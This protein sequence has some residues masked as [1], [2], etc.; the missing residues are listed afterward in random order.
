MTYLI[1]CAMAGV[2]LFLL[3]KLYLMKKSAREISEGFRRKLN[4][5]T[6]TQ[7]RISGHDKDMKRLASDV[8]EQ[9]VRLR[10]EQLIYEQGNTALKNA[11]TNISHDIRTP[12]TAIYGYLDMIQKTDDPGK[13][14]RYIAIMKDRAELM[15][16]LTEELFRYSVILADEN[17]LEISEVFVNQVL[18]E[19]ISG[20]YPALSEKGIIPQISITE[21]RI[22]R[23][24]DKAALSRVFAN[25][26]NNAVKYSDGDLEIVLSDTG[27]VRFTNTAKELSTVDVEQLFDR[28]YTVEAAHHST[29]LGLSIART[30]VE[31][32]GGSITAGYSGGRLTITIDLTR[33]QST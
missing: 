16:Q 29:G 6:N 33:T 13:Q 3:I 15:K 5:D 27:E 9:L 19:S 4:E 20:F 1:F 25:L 11:V 12:L 21:E 22:M 26:L 10:K 28:F 18:A 31:R 14:A 2:I 24:A 8:N 23:S 30:L 17:D 7:L 32:M